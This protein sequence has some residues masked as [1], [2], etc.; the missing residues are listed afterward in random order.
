MSYWC[1]PEWRK[2]YENAG[3]LLGDFCLGFINPL[4]LLSPFFHSLLEEL[5]ETLLGLASFLLDVPKCTQRSILVFTIFLDKTIL[6]FL[7]NGEILIIDLAFLCEIGITSWLI[8]ETD[9]R[10]LESTS[11][12]WE[13]LERSLL[14]SISA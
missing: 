4:L 14:S 6:A 11:L 7:K 5:V 2:S 12:K 9:L 1:V 8:W 10:L 13:F 3:A